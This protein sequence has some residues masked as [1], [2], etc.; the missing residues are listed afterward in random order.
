MIDYIVVGSGWRAEFYIRIAALA[1]DKFKVKAVYARNK[2]RASYISEKYKVKVTG[3]LEEALKEEFDF[4]VDC[5]NKAD[6]SDFAVSLADKG[7]Y[8]LSETPVTK[9]PEGEHEFDKI[10]VAEQ[11]HLK[12]TYKAIKKVID[13]GII[14]KINNI[15]ISA[16]HDYHAMSLLRFLLDDYNKPEIF[17]EY[18]F[19]DELLRTNGRY[20]ELEDKKLEETKQ[21]IKLFKFGKA[22]A[23]YNYNKEQYFSPIRKDRL[24]IRGQRGEIDNFRVGY[25]NKSDNYVESN[26][27]LHK[28]G[29]LNGFYNEK[30]TFEDKILYEFPFA[31]ARLSEEETAIAECL[32]G[33]KKY[34]LTGEELYSFERAYQDYKFIT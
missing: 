16:A 19:N 15:E 28:S 10:Q 1:P 6:V 20:G 26:I 17:G 24:L 11:F 34:I 29:L 14:G 30:I 22:A 18:S 27:K 3:T 9:M 12:G 2:E 23:I 13:M 21:I 33:M 8:V 31:A 7:Y 25:Y 5:I 4:V 32:E